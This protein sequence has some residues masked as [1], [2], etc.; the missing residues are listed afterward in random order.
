[1]ASSNFIHYFNGIFCSSSSQYQPKNILRQV[2]YIGKSTWASDELA[3]AVYD[4]LRI[5]NRVL[6]QDEIYSL[7]FF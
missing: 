6:T 2:N 5:Y 4:E 3:N 7:M 1:M